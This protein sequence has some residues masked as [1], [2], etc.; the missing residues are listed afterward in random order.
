MRRGVI[1][2]LGD[3]RQ[4]ADVAI[5]GERHGLKPVVIEP[6][7]LLFAGAALPVCTM[8]GGATIVGDIFSRSGAT[9]DVPSEGWGNYLAFG[10]EGAGTTIE[11]APLTGMPL[12]WVRHGAEILCASHLELL[13]DIL[14]PMSVDWAF[15]AH[16]LHFINLRIDR[17]GVTGLVEL[18]PGTRLTFDGTEARIEATW[19]PWNHPVVDRPVQDQARELER[20]IL[21]SVAALA[22]SRPEIVVELSGGLDSSIV[23]AALEAAGANFSAM[24]FATSAADG[25]E[26]FFARAVAARCGIE[27]AEIMGGSE[28]IDLVAPP[29]ILLPR[30]GAYSVLGGID[31]AFAAAI[32]DR[33]AAIFGGIGG[34]SVFALDGSVAPILEAF[35]KFGVGRRTFGALRDV[36]RSG[37]ATVWR[38][39]RLSARARRAGRRL[40]GRRDPKY[41]NPG[42]VPERQF[43]HP[44]DAGEGAASQARIN[45]VQAIRHI[46]DFLDRPARWHDR[47]VVAPLLTQPVVEHCLSVPSWTWFAG[48]R[49]RAVARSAF[50]H[51]LPAEVVWRRDKG[52]LESMC[53]AAYLRQRP[54]LRDLLLGGRLA[55]QGLLDRPAIEAYLAR[56][57]AEG[58]FDY[59]RLI[60]IGDVERWVRAVEGGGSVSGSA[61]NS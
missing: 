22:A 36:A 48:G 9:M 41:L 28:A 10:R 4:G 15:V 8:P 25:D 43:P 50:A 40:G 58:D 23:T 14:P 27:L 60:E 54:E 3:A 7:M 16:A 38:A 57:L 6:D 42:A 17:T 56:D 51:R 2:W 39:L 11:R 53:S 13:A 5:V 1:A 32:A 33:D 59:F 31:R 21:R 52:R 44:W 18:L 26:R 49:N 61:G 55:A 47:D 35:G 30:P 20:R 24:T 12:Y 29:D 34:D 46:L 19:S 45:H 37:N